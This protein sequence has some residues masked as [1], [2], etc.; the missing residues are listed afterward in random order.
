MDSLAQ[1]SRPRFEVTEVSS[2]T[3]APTPSPAQPVAP[4][5]SPN[6]PVPAPQQP[7]KQPNSPHREHPIKK[8]YFLIPAV[9]IVASIAIFAYFSRTDYV[10]REIPNPDIKQEIPTPSPAAVE[11]KPVKDL[12]FSTK[13]YSFSYPNTLSV[14]S[15]GDT[16]YISQTS[17]SDQDVELGVEHLCKNLSKA[18]VVAL[19]EKKNQSVDE[20]KYEI[21]GSEP[22]SVGGVDTEKV[23]YKADSGSNFYVQA[24]FEDN[25]YLFT[26]TNAEYE[27]DFSNILGSMKFIPDLTRD[28]ESYDNS[29]NGYILSYPKDW[30]IEQVYTKDSDKKKKSPDIII[31]KDP[32]EKTLQ[33][34]TIKVTSNSQ[35]AP[36]LASDTISSTKYLLGW[37]TTPTSEFRQI[38]GADAASIKGIFN[39]NWEVY[40]VVWFQNTVVEM[41]W[42]DGKDRAYDQVIEEILNNFK[43]TL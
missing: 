24:E 43:F 32:N 16:V 11:D 5:P 10:Q 20:T 37:A 4:I 36:L 12:Y 27:T 39:G 8:L 25:F 40:T 18:Q 17:T 6:P 38:D 42:V 41:T 28:W 19:I 1:N 22:L 31:R 13:S 14:Y 23:E 33:N 2:P 15:C 7:P 9:I 34:L 29:T 21:L 3:P 26:L 30:E 35:N